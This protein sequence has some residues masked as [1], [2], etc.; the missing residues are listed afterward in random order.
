GVIEHDYA[1][2]AT[3]LTHLDCVLHCGFLDVLPLLIGNN[4]RLGNLLHFSFIVRPQQVCSLPCV[5]D[6]SSCVDARP[7]DEA[8]GS[9]CVA[10]VDIRNIECTNSW[11]A[12]HQG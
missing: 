4:E 12:I 10:R 3:L 8:T 6:A 2:I 1:V 9:G 5:T 11:D 7:E